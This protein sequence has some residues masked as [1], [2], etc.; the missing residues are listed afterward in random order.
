MV[1]LKEAYFSPG[2]LH[3]IQWSHLEDNEIHEMTCPTKAHQGVVRKEYPAGARNSSI[4][5]LTP[6]PGLLPGFSRVHA[7]S[8]CLSEEGPLPSQQT[9]NVRIGI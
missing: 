2:K 3:K 8:H 7:E 5:V 4:A 9:L 1:L 6:T